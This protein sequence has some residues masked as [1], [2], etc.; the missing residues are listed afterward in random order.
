[1]CDD[2]CVFDYDGT[3]CGP[4]ET[5]VS[6][7]HIKLLRAMQSNFKLV[8]AT[9]RP[10]QLVPEI[11]GFHWDAAV[12]FNGQLCVTGNQLIHRQLLE[13]CEWRGFCR[14]AQR[15]NVEY[16]AFSD[17]IISPGPLVQ[18]PCLPEVTG[19]SYKI[20][21]PMNE[22]FLYKLIAE[23]SELVQRLVERHMPNAQIVKWHPGFWEIVPAG[24]DKV[25]GVERVLSHMDWRWDRVITF[26]DGRND[27]SLFR[28]ASCSVAIG[29]RCPELVRMATY[30]APGIEQ[31]GLEWA[32]M[33]IMSNED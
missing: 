4:K 22:P 15:E 5:S 1:M 28:K 9:G 25:A 31:K 12:Y 29:D 16:M 2:I 30:A 19:T 17:R 8:L 33:K 26:G 10:R 21:W 7:E 13:D 11:S 18:L 24:V 20:G 23:P 27:C 3:L 6:P 32:I 14:A